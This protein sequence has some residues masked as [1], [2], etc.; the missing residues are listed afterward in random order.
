MG[1]FDSIR[2][3]GLYLK[4]KIPLY[5][6]IFKL[7]RELEEMPELTDIEKYEI[8]KGILYPTE[9][10]ELGEEFE[11]LLEE[12]E[13]EYTLTNVE[14]IRSEG[15]S[16]CVSKYK[17]YLDDPYG[18][19]SRVIEG[20]YTEEDKAFINIELT[21]LRKYIE[22]QPLDYYETAA[23][24]IFQK[25]A[26]EIFKESVEEKVSVVK[27]AM[28][29]FKLPDLGWLKWALIPVGIIIFLIALGYSGIIGLAKR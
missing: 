12:S 17:P 11:M 3:T 28:G 13:E 2:T 24:D 8:G 15:Y 19:C 23:G 16:A 1:I 21:T 7:E 6:D 14:K 18:L 9:P 25:P 10:E 26:P 27:E 4:E 20:S 29:D 22:E 5:G